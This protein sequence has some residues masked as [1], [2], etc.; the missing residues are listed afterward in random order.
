M[1]LSAWFYLQGCDKENGSYKGSTLEPD[2]T[3]LPKGT[4]VPE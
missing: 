2:L 4:V 3:I 1:V